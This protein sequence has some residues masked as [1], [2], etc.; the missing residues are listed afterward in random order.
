M[1]TDAVHN[2]DT[3]ICNCHSRVASVRAF[4]S[5]VASAHMT[6]RVPRERCISACSRHRWP[7]PTQTERHARVELRVLT[8]SCACCSFPSPLCGCPPVPCSSSSLLRWLSGR[9]LR[10]SSRLASSRCSWS[11][12]GRF[13][14]RRDAAQRADADEHGRTAGGTIKRRHL[15]W[16]HGR[17]RTGGR[18]EGIRSCL[19]DAYVQ[20]V[21]G[22][23]CR[24]VEWRGGR[25]ARCVWWWQLTA[26]TGPVSMREEAAPRGDSTQTAMV[27]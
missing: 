5:C 13:C 20:A 4:L 10:R 8:W 6:G 27:A 21:L 19:Y 17:R 23:I 11:R 12:S 16:T 2:D 7:T 1:Q 15:T 14:R 3:L 22:G 18:S 24:D 26:T 9:P 25:V